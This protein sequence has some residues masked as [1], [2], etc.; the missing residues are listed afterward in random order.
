MFLG[1]L[2]GNHRKKKHKLGVVKGAEGEVVR[3]EICKIDD[4]KVI[5]KKKIK[6]NEET[7]KGDAEIS[8][9]KATFPPNSK[10]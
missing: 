8:N 7:K 6:P 9:K 10:R 4:D 5:S 1:S 3:D 2:F